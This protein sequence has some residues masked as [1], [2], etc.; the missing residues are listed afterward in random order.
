ML[1]ITASIRYLTAYILLLIPIVTIALPL[2]NN[3]EENLS[4]STRSRWIS[5]LKRLLVLRYRGLVLVL[6]AFAIAYTLSMPVILTDFGARSYLDVIRTFA[7]VGWNG[8]VLYFGREQPAQQIPWHYVFGYLFVQLPLFYHLFLA[9]FIAVCALRPRRLWRAL[10][11][12]DERSSASLIL[13][14]LAVVIP[15]AL[16][17]IVRP[18]LFDGFRHV[19]FVVPLL[20][21]LLYLSFVLAIREI[22]GVT[23]GA[24]VAVAT[25][26]WI[27]SVFAMR[28]LHPYEYTYYNPLVNPAGSF[29]LDYWGTSLREVAERLNEYA[30]KTTKRDD[31]I[32]VS[33]CGPEPPL[34]L[35]LDKEKFE[36][37]PSDV[38]Q[39]RVAL[40]RDHCMALLT[41]PWLVS[42]KRGNL[43]FAVAAKNEERSLGVGD[44]KTLED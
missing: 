19:L 9:T 14:V 6:T 2:L 12:L 40:N 42:V 36:I 28:S 22:G 15:F 41:G 20:C 34:T 17:L 24:I 18:V 7:H 3:R 8:T 31:K 11:A 43:I 26:F 4:V 10:L 33:I 32:R 5:A 16:I 23:H 27:Q 1:G 25:I 39:V 38:G 13:L 29:E 44:E 21:M 37:V 30:R 35:F